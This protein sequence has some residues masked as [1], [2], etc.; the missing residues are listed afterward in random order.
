MNIAGWT[1]TMQAAIDAV[2]TEWA[3]LYFVLFYFI[4]VCIIMNIL[5]GFAQETMLDAMQEDLAEA[6]QQNEMMVA[7]LGAYKCYKPAM[8][9]LVDVYVMDWVLLTVFSVD[10]GLRIKS[11]KNNLKL[12]HWVTFD[13]CIMALSILGKLIFECG[14]P[15]SRSLSPLSVVRAACIFC[16]LRLFRIMTMSQVVR[17]VMRVML[18]VLST[19]SKFAACSSSSIT[20]SLA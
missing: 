15:V 7:D 5:I 14:G 2:Q 3:S 12:T 6:R 20:S 8:Q 13:I 18:N 11:E 17:Q 16:T 1:V 19:L 10:V 9:P 4:C